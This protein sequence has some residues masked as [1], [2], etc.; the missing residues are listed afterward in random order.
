MQTDIVHTPVSHP[1]PPAQRA[2]WAAGNGIAVL[3]Q[4]VRR[5]PGGWRYRYIR[6]QLLMH[7]RK[8]A[9]PAIIIGKIR[10]TTT[11]ASGSQVNA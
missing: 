4:A 7:P 2:A 8:L 9:Q 11:G 3:A 10:R 1:D 6:S 5:T